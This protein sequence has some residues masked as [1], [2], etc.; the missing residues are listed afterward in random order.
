MSALVTLLLLVPTAQE[1]DMSWLSENAGRADSRTGPA[2]LASL[3]PVTISARKSVATVLLGSG[4]V[5]LA[6]VVDEAGLLIAKA[7]E[8]GLADDRE[9]PAQVLRVRL[10][11]GRTLGAEVLGRD[12]NFDLVLLQVEADELTPITWSTRPAAVGRL[13]VSLEGDGTPLGLGVVGVAPKLIAGGRARLGLV[14]AFGVEGALVAQVKADTAAEVAGLEV[15]DRILRIEDEQV[16][17]RRQAAALLREHQA[18]ERIRLEVQR[19]EETLEL[20]AVLTMW[21]GAGST[22]RSR[23]VDGERSALRS[24][25]PAALQHDTVLAPDQCGSPLLGLD[26]SAVGLNIARA[27][28][29][30]TYAI[31]AAD[32]QASVARLR[33]GA[34][35]RR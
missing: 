10:A 9:R 16:A 3:A 18:G 22:G 23:G 8:A 25:F 12:L 31:P 32:V 34:L 14:L 17:D 11:D 1:P 21:T 33:A 35:E 27:G 6:T 24:G 5:G 29:V 7:S 4:E 2:V 26:G 15:G 30:A 28:R 13:V 19:G 20:E